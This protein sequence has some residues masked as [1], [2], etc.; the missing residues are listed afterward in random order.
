MKIVDRYILFALIKPFLFCIIS[1]FFLWI[2]YDLF[3]HL[4]DFVENKAPFRLILKFYLVQ[5]PELAQI[6][7]PISYFFALLY[8]LSNMSHYRELVGMQSG[9]ISL[10]RISITLF[11]ISLLVAAFQYYLFFDLTPRATQRVSDTLN[12][13]QGKPSNAHTFQQVIYKSPRSGIVWYAQTVDVAQRRAVQVEIL[14]PHTETRRDSRKIFAAQAQYR[15]GIWELIRCRVV[16]FDEDGK[17]ETQDIDSIQADFLTVSPHQMI[18][19]L[20]LPAHMT[21]SE[22]RQFIFGNP[23]PSSIRMAPFLTQYY[24]RM[25]YPLLSPILF[26]FSIALAVTLE[27]QNR[28]APLFK[29][30]L[31]LFLL[32]IWLNFS[33]ALGNGY[34]IPAWLAAFNPIAVFGIAGLYLFAEKVGWIWILVH[35]YLPRQTTDEA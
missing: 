18:A 32:L 30:L 5:M 20:R 12:E 25:A 33:L 17:T 1:F 22:L 27:R 3:D 11:L 31:V 16:S 2:I 34:R 15:T 7:L 26:L 9:G 29:C 21:W 28:A 35:R 13:I 19:A 6:I 23:H 14:I 24:Y 4:T 8:V 10:Q